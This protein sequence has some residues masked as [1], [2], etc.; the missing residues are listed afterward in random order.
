MAKRITLIF[1]AVI[2]VLSLASCEGGHS[3]E[4]I[5]EAAAALIEKSYEV[6]EIYYGK[7]LPSTGESSIGLAS[8][9]SIV[10]PS[11][12]YT[13]VEQ[14]KEVAARVYSADYCEHLYV[15]AFEGISNDEDEE[16]ASF[17]RY[18]VD[19]SDTLTVSNDA[20]ENGMVL[21]RTYD[22]STIVVE[23]CVRNSATISVQSLV[24][25]VADQIIELNLVYENG[26]W[27]LNTPT[28]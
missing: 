8:E 6:N 11:C 4:E 2:E 21:N 12:G 9:Y 25:G 26:E 28:Y 27:R 14:I 20:E 5:I 3:D 13:T 18:I 19:F 10:D 15:I 23:K 17:A 22:F 24:D 16:S 1:I 7:G